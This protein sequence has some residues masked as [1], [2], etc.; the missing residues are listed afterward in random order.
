[1]YSRGIIANLLVDVGLA[2][3]SFNTL[4]LSLGQLDDVA[5]QRVLDRVSGE[6]KQRD[7]VQHTKTI[8]TLGAMVTGMIFQRSN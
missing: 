5:V 1:M 6:G 3:S 4:L 2:A 8:A 7:R